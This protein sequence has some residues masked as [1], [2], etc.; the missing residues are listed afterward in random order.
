MLHI[1]NFSTIFGSDDFSITIGVIA[2]VVLIASFIPYIASILAGK[3]KP[4]RA[5]WCIWSFLSILL[6]FSYYFSGGR[7]AIWVSIGAVVV[8][9][10]IALLSLR[11]KYGVG[12]WTKFDRGIIAGC[13]LCLF[14]WWI[15]N[16]A[17]TALTMAMLMDALGA[18]PTIKKIHHY[19]KQEDKWAWIIAFTAHTLNLMAVEQWDYAH[20]AYP[21]YLFLEVGLIMILVVLSLIHI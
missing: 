11:K 7:T 8:F 15:S 9:T 5:T 12:G 10:T 1:I 18:I 19:P 21:L 16:S 2:G 13:G 14:I 20:A 6:L 3:T 17:I 4:Q